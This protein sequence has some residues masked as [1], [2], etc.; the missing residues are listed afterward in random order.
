MRLVA[1]GTLSSIILRPFRN[2]LILALMKGNTL[3]F[4]RLSCV[5]LQA[6]LY[7]AQ[8]SELEGRTRE[9]FV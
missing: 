9:T 7:L 3:A 4:A 8:D 2:C 6:D 5:F 1:I